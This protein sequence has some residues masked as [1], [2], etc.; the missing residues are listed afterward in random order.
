MTEQQSPLE[1]RLTMVERALADV[2][3][4]VRAIESG[5][6]A[7][8]AAPSPALVAPL[9]EVPTVDVAGTFALIGRTFV[10]FAGAY[11]LRALTESGVLD[12]ASGATLGLAYA[13][14]LAAV[15]YRVAPRRPV[16]ATFFG[17]CTVIVALPLLWETTT[18]FAL[19][20]PA[21]GAVALAGTVA[22][23]LTVAWRR[24]LQALAWIATIGSCLLASG[25]LVATG[26]PVPFTVF[27]IIL[28][29]ATLW[30]GYDRGWIALRWIAALFADLAVLIL[31]ARALATPPRDD[32]ARVMGVQMLLL[33]GYLGS[34]GVRTL[35]RKRDVLPF[36][37][38][39]TAALL[40]VGLAGAMLI[41][42][43]TGA[44]AS[45]L[46]PTLLLLAMACY[47]AA[48]VHREWHARAA[49]YYF[50][51]T[52]AIVFALAGGAF[53]FT[54]APASVL[55][56]TLA[57]VMV[58]LGRRYRRATLHVHAIVYL[59]AGAWTS[60]LAA[61]IFASLFA[62]VAASLVVMN[63]T[64]WLVAAA[65]VVCWCI[66]EVS[67]P[68]AG[69]RVPR[70]ML[71]L[72]LVV[73]AAAV[74]VTLVFVLLRGEGDLMPRPALV[75]T[76][77]TGV[78]AAGA[79]IVAWLGARPT[80]PEFGWLL[81]PMLGWGLLKLLFED[82]RVSPPSLL[83]VAFALYGAALI[84]APRLGKKLSSVMKAAL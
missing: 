30:L 58:W 31:I 48:F 15:A 81:Y 12:R 20:T 80:T 47:A 46:G 24:N 45:M 69:R 27:L 78:F 77:R 29:I 65:I 51:T 5:L 18:R 35:V 67:S 56:T 55:W 42:D 74:C 7:A 25:L 50:Y 34:V 72:F 40:L 54:N 23:I 38:T 49:N 3:R 60:G 73:T 39:Q 21:M 16:S 17:A 36:E 4:R 66:A 62:P 10:L 53:M 1:A 6:P 13:L 76:I 52:L 71:T 64:A 43:R 33:V 59:L 83:F 82:F 26:T 68:Q 8:S 2:D 32:P 19:L 44:G 41:A 9:L 28:G 75:A 22:A 37:A 61:H 79:V 63:R 70:A 14:A 84:I 57:I 11:L